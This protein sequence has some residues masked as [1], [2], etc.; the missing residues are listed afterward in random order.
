[1]KT[2]EEIFRALA[3]DEDERLLLAQ[4]WD[5]LETCR[6]RCYLTATRFLDLHER[7]LAEDAVRLLG[8]SNECVF[9]GGYEDAERV[10][11]IFFPD[12]L[13]AEDAVSTENSPICLLRAAK[14]PADTLAHRDYL[15]ALMGLQIERAM[16]GDI[17]VHETGADIFVMR[18]MADFVRLHFDRAGR[19]RITLAEAPVESLRRAAAEEIEGDGSVASLRLDSVAALVFGLSRAEAQTRIEKGTVFLNNRACLKPDRE[20][21]EGDK[22]TVR[23]LGRARVVS[24]G[25]VSRKGRRFVHFVKSK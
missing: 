20:I 23:G 5:R 12:Y 21:G 18:E 9:Y 3:H 17:L 1:M 16:I 14:S 6:E 2:R 24:L 15:G 19:R 8:A 7:A 10:C 13:T 4:L 11:A 22:L 25:G